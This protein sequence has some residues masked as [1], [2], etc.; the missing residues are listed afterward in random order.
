MAKFLLENSVDITTQINKITVGFLVDFDLP[1]SVRD[2][3]PMDEVA[4]INGV[5]F[6]RFYDSPMIGDRL[7]YNGHEWRI[8]ERCFYLT[9][10]HNQTESKHVPIIKVEYLGVVPAIHDLE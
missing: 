2:V 3:L 7:V 10:Y 1:E 6:M 4:Q 5:L 9:R 8:I